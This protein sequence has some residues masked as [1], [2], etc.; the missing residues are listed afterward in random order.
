MYELKLANQDE[1]TK[2]SIENL[3]LE[4]DKL[5][6]DMEHINKL[7]CEL[8]AFHYDKIDLIKSNGLN[9]KH[10]REGSLCQ[11]F[12]EVINR[13]DTLKASE[14]N[15]K[16]EE[17]SGDVNELEEE[18]LLKISDYKFQIEKFKMDRNQLKLNSMKNTL[19]LE[20]DNLV[21]LKYF[22]EEDDL[23]IE[24][25]DILLDK[26]EGD[27]AHMELFFNKTTEIDIEEEC[28]RDQSN[29]MENT[30]CIDVRVSREC[31]ETNYNT[32]LDGE[33]LNM[34]NKES[35]MLRNSVEVVNRSG[36]SDQIDVTVL[37]VETGK[38]K[39]LMKL[40]KFKQ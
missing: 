18:C 40:R 4:Y 10:S 37:I 8:N 19:D 33:S 32:S 31:L 25:E 23:L 24:S 26:I 36:P 39:L 2:E 35:Q 16:L 5:R 14:L 27:D 9:L 13:V 3:E 30:G 28:F 21:N 12:N 6:I 38:N 1:T 34:T 7:K 22:N 15:G 17:I 20:L 11:G 29:Y